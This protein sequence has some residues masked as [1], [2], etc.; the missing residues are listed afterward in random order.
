MGNCN[1]YTRNKCCKCPWH[2][3][4]STD[5]EAPISSQG[6]GEK[7]QLRR[8]GLLRVLQDGHP[9]Q[10]TADHCSDPLPSS[11]D[12]TSL[13][14]ALS[15]TM[16]PAQPLLSPSALTVLELCWLAPAGIASL[17][18][19]WRSSKWM[20]QA[21]FRPGGRARN[22]DTQSFAFWTGDEAPAAK[23]GT[24]AAPT[25]TWSITAFPSSSS[26]MSLGQP[27]IQWEAWLDFCCKYWFHLSESS[28]QTAAR[29]N[30]GRAGP[31]CTSNWLMTSSCSIK[32]MKVATCQE[33]QWI[34]GMRTGQGYKAHTCFLLTRTGTAEGPSSTAPKWA[35]Y[36]ITTVCT[37]V[38][39]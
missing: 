16:K 28:L 8:E 15:I 2:P 18:W 21:G 38:F 37:A 20:W 19:Q 6:A 12:T 4:S 7:S 29:I 34:T 3:T 33:T 11:E 35:P 14:V 9:L 31:V 25:T 39:F 23:Q 30:V 1:P 13:Q 27:Q 32:A 22:A 5:Q 26:L 10:Q 36:K 24:L 17:L